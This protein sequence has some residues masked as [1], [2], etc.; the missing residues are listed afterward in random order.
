M[1]KVY[2]RGLNFVGIQLITKGKSTGPGRTTAS[3]HSFRSSKTTKWCLWDVDSCKH[4]TLCPMGSWSRAGTT[5]IHWR[6]RG[7]LT[8]TGRSRPCTPL[9]MYAGIKVVHSV[10]GEGQHKGV[11]GWLHPAEQ[12]AHCAGCPVREGR[13]R[14]RWGPGLRQPREYV[15]DWRKLLRSEGLRGYY[16]QWI[17]NQ[18]SC[19]GR[20][21]LE[22]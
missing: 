6:V 11:L 15:P 18:E 8:S 1:R 2:A 10:D 19:M 13:H 4:A 22:F 16:R 7:C 20:K 17:W 3:S 12:G 14:S 21:H 5:S 9:S